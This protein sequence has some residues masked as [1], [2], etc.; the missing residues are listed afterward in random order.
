MLAVMTIDQ[1]RSRH[2]VDRVED[3]LVELNASVGD[4]GVLAFERTAGDEVQGV[5]SQPDVVIDLTLRCARSNHWRVGV[6][7]GSIREPVPDSTRRASGSAFERARTAIGRARSSPAGVAVTG[8]EPTSTAYA[9]AVLATLVAVC[10]TRSPAGWEAVDLMSAG[11]TQVE[12]AH[13]LKISK[14][15]ISQRLTAAWWWHEKH[16]RPVAAALLDEAAA[17]S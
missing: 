3:L 15:A 7:L 8:P 9:E 10:Q 12:A 4:A 11:R 2:D 14:Q 16:L 5:L 17:R 6:G 1:R 13:I